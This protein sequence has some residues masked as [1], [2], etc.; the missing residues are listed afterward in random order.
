MTAVRPPA[1]NGLL[2]PAAEPDNTRTS[3][4]SG[5][6]VF[7][8]AAPTVAVG[9]AVLVTGKV[10]DFY[11]LARWR[12]V[13]TTASLSITEIAPTADHQAQLGQPA[14]GAAG[15]RPRPPFPTPTPRHHRAG[16]RRVDRPGR[17]DRSALEF[18]EAHEGM[19]VE[20]DNARV[21]GPGKPQFGEIYVTT[22]PDQ[23][24]TYRGG[25]YVKSYLET[26]S[27]RLLDHH[28]STARCRRPTSATS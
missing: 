22:K 3:A 8:S 2:D 6:F 4:S 11:P 21:V 1:R 17:P 15:A 19:L 7:T 9:D 23:Q 25:T 16:Q 24:E 12:D 14:A 27:G 10:S 18:W 13:A 28:R 26:P 20:V 5:V